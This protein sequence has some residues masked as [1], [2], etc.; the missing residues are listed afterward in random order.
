[1]SERPSPRSTFLA[2]T[3]PTASGKTA[4]SLQVAARLGGEIISMD[5][6]QIYRG[7]D[8]G[9]AKVTS[10][11]RGSIPHHG[12]DLFDPSEAYSAGRFARDARR[13]IEDIR[14]RD[15]LP[16]LVGGT[17]FFL[18]ALMEPL[19]DEP[20]MEV[21]R[22][23]ALRTFL[24]GLETEDLAAWTQAL[25]PEAVPEVVRGGR[26]RMIRSATV[27]TLS[28]RPLSW[29][30]AEQQRTGPSAE[31]CSGLVVVLELPADVLDERIANRVGRMIA[32]GLVEEVEALVAAGY[33]RQSPGLTG[34]GY[35]EV[36]DYLEGAVGLDEAMERIR[37]ATRQ[38]AKRQLTW[39]RNQMPPEAVRVDGTQ[40][41]V[42]LADQ[43]LQAWR[44]RLED[45]QQRGD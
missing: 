33:G 34:T 25:D 9:T 17:G 20:P 14:G 15:R 27:A 11:E 22:R 44:A 4:V 1:M 24:E 42:V 3:G 30:H 40:P 8:V 23:A 21:G 35:R 6:R 10:A 26:Q 16:I 2:I 38:Y 39:F 31:A 37:I 43:I 18:R 12:L 29:W 36:L 28:G 41:T 7:M 13:W 45:Q 5:S 19:F 32:S